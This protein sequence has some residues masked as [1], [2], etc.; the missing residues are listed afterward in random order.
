[1]NKINSSLVGKLLKLRVKCNDDVEEGAGVTFR[2]FKKGDNPDRDRPVFET[3]GLNN[4]GSAVAEWNTRDIR[5][6]AD[7]SDLG[8][9]FTAVTMRA[10]QIKS[11][12][13]E[14]K[15]PQIIEIKWE[16]DYIYQY[17]EACLHISSF[18]TAPTDDILIE[19]QEPEY[20]VV[21][22][23]ECDFLTKKPQQSE[24]LTIGK[25]GEHE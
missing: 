13:L 4:G 12:D 9:F 2:V 6:S 15:N 25:S 14:V 5:E 19:K 21:A 20:K 18:E 17:S 7:K 3:S 8:Y 11:D 10:K 1:M 16:P 23:V 22:K 24:F